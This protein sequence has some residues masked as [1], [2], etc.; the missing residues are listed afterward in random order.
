MKT[1]LRVA[2]GMRLRVPFCVFLPLFLTG[3]LLSGCRDSMDLSPDQ[4]SGDTPGVISA[5]SSF[6][7]ATFDSA[8]WN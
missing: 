2:S 5:D 8:T 7:T 4:R 6:D 1:S 3:V